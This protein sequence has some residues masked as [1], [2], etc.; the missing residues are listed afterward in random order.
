MYTISKATDGCDSQLD[1]AT[2]TALL[3]VL[4]AR[5]DIGMPADMV[6]EDALSAAGFV[7]AAVS[8]AHMANT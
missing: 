4:I 7:F 2:A 6:R 3:L 8:L 5:D 1:R